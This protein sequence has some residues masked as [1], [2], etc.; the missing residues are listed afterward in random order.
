MEYAKR[1]DARNE[2]AR[3][4][5][6]AERQQIR[7]ELAGQGGRKTSHAWVLGGDPGRS[8]GAAMQGNGMASC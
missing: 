1:L 6:D 7:E 2:L 4:I 8:R 3:E 5:A